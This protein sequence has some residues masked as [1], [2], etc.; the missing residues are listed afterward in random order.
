MANEDIR[1]EIKRAGVMKWQ[2]A[3]E[4]GIHISTFSIWLRHEMLPEQKA[5]IRAAIRKLTK[6]DVA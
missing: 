3:D 4:V 6:G 1:A 5:A 2:I